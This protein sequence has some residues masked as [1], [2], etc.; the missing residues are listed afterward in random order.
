MPRKVKS[1]EVTVAIITLVGVIT[2]S[3]ISNINPIKNAIGD[4]YI[5]IHNLIYPTPPPIPNTELQY[6]KATERL[7][8]GDY[9]GALEMFLPLA[10]L[11][12]RRAQYQIGKIYYLDRPGINKNYN[13]AFQ[14]THKSASQNLPEALH[15]LGVLYQNGQ[16]VKQNTNMAFTYYTK[17]AKLNYAPSQ[18]VLIAAGKTW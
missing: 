4:L 8:S 15:N 5:F 16:G 14:W 1:T 13:L 12:D 2:T 7:N 17:A 3:T 10:N 9:K 18:A 6:D 11:G